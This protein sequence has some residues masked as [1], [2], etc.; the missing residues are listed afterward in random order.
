MA[1]QTKA[2][3]ILLVR[4]RRTDLEA[5]CDAAGIDYDLSGRVDDLARTPLAEY[6]AAAT[7]IRLEDWEASADVL[8]R[9]RASHPEHPLRTEATKQMARVYREQ[10]D[11]ARA[12]EEY[13]RASELRDRIRRVELE[14]SE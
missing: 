12:A 7:L 3:R 8:E 4:R 6:D 5:L 10:G 13:E 14:Q 1:R 9:F 2:P 11:D